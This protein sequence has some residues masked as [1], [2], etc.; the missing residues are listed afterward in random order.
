VSIQVGS[1]TEGL[2]P[3]SFDLLVLS[4]I[5]YY[6]TPRDWNALLDRLIAPLEPGTTV[7]ASHWLGESDD[8]LMHGDDVHAILRSRRDLRLTQQERHETFRLDRWERA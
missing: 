6:F 4:E 8:H 1:L 7:L 5:G 3:G 2:P